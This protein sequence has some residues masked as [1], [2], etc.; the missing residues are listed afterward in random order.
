MIIVYHIYTYHYT[1]YCHCYSVN[2]TCVA[3]HPPLSPI[4]MVVVV[5]GRMVHAPLHDF[6]TYLFIT[7]LCT[8]SR[9]H[10]VLIYYLFIYLCTTS[11]CHEVLIYYL[12][13]VTCIFIND[14]HPL[15]CTSLHTILCAFNPYTPIPQLTVEPCQP[16]NS[17]Q[18]PST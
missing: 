9:C 17:T 13:I 12:F 4:A 6:M 7:Y 3:L 14:I 15:P 11:R 1:I 8:T 16:N 10:E 5:R 18:T 2:I